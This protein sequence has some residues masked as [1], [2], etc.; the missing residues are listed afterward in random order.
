MELLSG[1]PI[2]TNVEF[3]KMD[4][5][6]IVADTIFSEEPIRKAARPHDR[7]ALVSKPAI[8]DFNDLFDDALTL[9]QC[10]PNHKIY[11]SQ[12]RY[13]QIGVAEWL[14]MHRIIQ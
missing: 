14:D 4:E 9:N 8:T 3:V 10:I 13:M 5:N 1:I 6:N 2:A 7:D 12:V 11:L